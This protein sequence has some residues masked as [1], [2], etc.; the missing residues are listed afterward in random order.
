MSGGHWQYAGG[1]IRDALFMLSEDSDLNVR[2]PRLAPLFASLAVA[3]YDAEREMD[4][5]LSSDSHIDD[6]VAFEDRVILSVLVPTMEAARD[7]L[8]PRGKWATIQAV[9]ARA[10]L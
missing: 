2:W 10:N 9:Q 4:W 7:Q 6:D 3:I 8:F 5:D 1:P